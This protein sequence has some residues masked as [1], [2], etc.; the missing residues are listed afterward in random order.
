MLVSTVSTVPTFGAE[1]DCRHV[2]S[3]FAME[4]RSDL[5]LRGSVRGVHPKKFKAA[6]GLDGCGCGI[7]HSKSTETMP[8]TKRRA[9][10]TGGF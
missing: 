1:S 9:E 6:E 7:Q 4:R 10:M 2:E 8:G 5:L 3:A